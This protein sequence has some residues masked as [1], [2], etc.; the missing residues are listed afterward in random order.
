MK[1]LFYF[2]PMAA[3]LCACVEQQGSNSDEQVELSWG[4]AAL[5]IENPIAPNEELCYQ[6]DFNIDTLAG[7]SELAK[8][9]VTVIRDSILCFQG[10]ANSVQ[11]M[12]NLFAEG[13]EKG[14]KDEISERYEPESEY[15]DMFQ[16]YYGISGTP[17]ENGLDSIMSYQATTDTYLGG[18]HGSHY[19]RYY[20]FQASTGKLLSISEIVPAEKEM[21]VLMAMEEQLCKDWE[22]KDLADLQ[23]KT[24]ITMLGNLYLTDNFLLKGDSI[25]FLFNQYEIAPYSSGLISVTLPRP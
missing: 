16:Y 21:L 11:E 1:K 6:I 9:L 22:A 20:N 24:G 15:K 12:V 4:K 14:W 25:E 2:L 10:S 7:E 17:V 13:V 3:L 19:I 18:A 8:S 23:E 5:C